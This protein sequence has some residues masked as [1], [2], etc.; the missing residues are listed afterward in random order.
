M[1]V[2]MPLSDNPKPA[3][4]PYR[5][6]ISIARDVPTACDAVPM[7][8]LSPMVLLAFV[9]RKTLNPKMA[10]KM[11]VHTTDDTVSAGIPPVN[12]DTCIAIGVVT[13]LG[14]SESTT[15]SV[16]PSHLAM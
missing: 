11:P 6:L 10:P 7:L 9:R 4:A 16:A 2:R 3:Y 14:A 13:D 12:S 15:S 5:G 1:A 8:R